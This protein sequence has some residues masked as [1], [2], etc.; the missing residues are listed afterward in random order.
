MKEKR[1]K[2]NRLLDL[3]I[4]EQKE[5]MEERKRCERLLEKYLK[6]INYRPK[7]R[8]NLDQNPRYELGK[9]TLLKK[10]ISKSKIKRIKRGKALLQ[11]RKKIQES[12]IKTEPT[13]EMKERVQKY[14]NGISLINNNKKTKV[15]KPDL[16]E[17]M[18]MA[19]NK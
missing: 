16:D 3:K 2:P 14:T 15:E 1:M 12:S 17:I 13:L 18:E 4:K 9:N 6:K 10:V 8:D 11:K 19:L 5:I 7:Q